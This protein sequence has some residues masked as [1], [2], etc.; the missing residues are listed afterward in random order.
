MSDSSTSVSAEIISAT[1]APRRSLS[2]KRISSVAT[3]SFSLITGTALR[4]SNVRHG[5]ARVEVAAALLGIVERQ[6]DLRHR[7]AVSRQRLLVGMRELDLAG[8]GGGLAFLEF[9][10]A[11]CKLEMGAAETDGAGRHQ[12][13]LAAALVEA[14]DIV[15]QRLEPVAPDFAPG[16][17]DQD[18]RADLDDQPLGAGQ[19]S[20]AASLAESPR[21]S[22][23]LSTSFISSCSRGCTPWPETPEIT[24]TVLRL[25]LASLARLASMSSA[26]MASVLL[27]ATSSFLRARLPP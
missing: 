21:V 4:P 5:L 23:C 14:R 25:A 19:R 7:D 16:F 22:R 13:D 1:R 17:I 20:H 9:E 2:P 3:V 24:C 12:H 6:Q 8:R 15:G 11:R 26:V 18:R 10:R 27:S